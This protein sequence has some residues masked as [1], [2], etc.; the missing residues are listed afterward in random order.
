MEF[1]RIQSAS[2]LST[3]R[4][5]GFSRLVFVA[6]A[7]WALFVAN[8]IRA[9][10]QTLPKL[11]ATSGT[12]QTAKE[13]DPFDAKP[14][15]DLVNACEQELGRA[16]D[17]L[18]QAQKSEQKG[19][20]RQLGATDEEITE[21]TML[22][23]DIVVSL[24]QRLKVLRR[25]KTIRDNVAALERER[26]SWDGFT[27]TSVITIDFVDSLRDT[28]EIRRQDLRAAKAELALAEKK[29]PG[30]R[31]ARS[32][33]ERGLLKQKEALER[34]TDPAQKPILEWR[35]ELA[36]LRVYKATVELDQ[37]LAEQR[38]AKESEQFYS[39]TIEFLQTQLQVANQLAPISSETLQ[40]KM[41]S[42]AAMRA[43]TEKELERARKAQ[44]ATAAALEE[45]RA[46]LATLQ[47]A[48][49]SEEVRAQQALLKPLEAEREALADTAR[50]RVDV[51]ELVLTLIGLQETL[52][53]QRFDMRMA[54]MGDI[55]KRSDALDRAKN[56]IEATRGKLI[57]PRLDLETNASRTRA[58]ISAAEER[59]SLL[60]DD[61]P[62][63][64]QISRMLESY[65][66]RGEICRLGLQRVGDVERLL[67]RWEN[68]NEQYA[69]SRTWLERLYA[70]MRDVRLWGGRVWELEL[71][72][73]GD[74]VIS[75]D[76][77][78]KVLA[79][80]LVGA[81]FSRRIALRIRR[82]AL[83]K[84]R[85][86]E[87]VAVPIEV[88]V[89]YTLIVLT[90]LFALSVVHI[91][92]TVFAYLG[93]AL[94]I[95]VG[96]GAQNLIGNF[97]S[98]IIMLLERPIKIGDIVEVDGVFGI[99]RK[100]GARCSHLRR[101][102]GI[103]MLV[104]NSS[105]LEKNV[106]NW[107]LSDRKVRFSISVG[108]AYGS[109]TREVERLILQAAEEHPRVLAEP[110]PVVVFEN[111]A[112]NALVFVCYFWIEL[113]REVDSRTVCSDL[114]HRVNELLHAANITIAFPQ[115]DV[116]LDVQRPVRVALVQVEDGQ[117]PH[118]DSSEETPN[119]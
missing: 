20:A 111:F 32:D 39:Q 52:W 13:A 113:F 103:D 106:V 48:G 98:G 56:L 62:E 68:E 11:S 5:C 36:S 87:S 55:G 102:D 107:T 46:K 31:V 10:S 57:Q 84:L 86:E 18:D 96:F 41:D 108:V 40:A 47:N 17:A 116:H 21:R 37:A 109:P 15:D 63:K 24:E 22:L 51:H 82:V 8:P 70:A 95:G 97:I 79:I 50:T 119:R 115:R 14:I 53:K 7:I 117:A 54:L 75:I 99:V 23:Q 76:K 74:A 105:F 49:D 110:A 93:G 112:D 60:A 42:L 94:A 29:V 104:P 45:I 72:R 3:L 6:L 69:S 66:E 80:I 34:N 81:F 100:I 64:G 19:T 78:V 59:L 33:A 9:Y 67:D 27:D 85:I 38:A 43:Q 44:M 114:R 4:L 25:I 101:F 65:Y 1:A 73:V 118:G 77:V 61:A 88:G 71:L 2:G 91:P 26:S 90:V 16:R 83:A 92:L 12:E 28:M 58:L 30:L 35:A 89:F